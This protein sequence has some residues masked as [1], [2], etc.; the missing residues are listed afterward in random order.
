[1][2]ENEEEELAASYPPANITSITF[3]A[4][5]SPNV[6][7]LHKMLVGASNLQSINMTSQRGIFN[8]ASGT[9]P[10]IRTLEVSLDRWKFEKDDVLRI[11]NFSNLENLHIRDLYYFLRTVKPEYFQRLRS[12]KGYRYDAS[13]L[14]DSMKLVKAIRI[15]SYKKLLSPSALSSTDV[16][17]LQKSCPAI[18]ELDLG[19]N[20]F[21]DNHAQF[22][23]A[24]TTFPHLRTLTLRTQTIGT[25]LEEANLGRNLDHEF[26]E[27][28]WKILRSPEKTL[29]LASLKV[30]ISQLIYLDKPGGSPDTL[31]WKTLEAS[32]HPR[33]V[34]RTFCVSWKDDQPKE[35]TF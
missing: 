4:A 9:L 8:P 2:S 5:F 13:E 14:S 34:I 24:I 31:Y 32:G 1:M 33:R 22:L 26:V 7:A 19:I 29:P 3:V 18:E 12:F 16:A 11:W 25:E 10:A 6:N 27:S 15:G 28:A 35:R 30:D 20:R 17:V 21:N 23:Q